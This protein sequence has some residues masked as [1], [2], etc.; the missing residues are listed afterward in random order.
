MPKIFP[1]QS[2]RRVLHG[3]IASGI[4]IF[5]AIAL[6]VLVVPVFLRAGGTSFL[7][8]W[9]NFLALI[10]LVS[11]SDLGS[12]D[13]IAAE[14]AKQSLSGNDGAAEHL[15]RSGITL[16]QVVWIGVALLVGMGAFWLFPHATSPGA[17]SLACAA[18]AFSQ[19]QRLAHGCFRARGLYGKGLSLINV[20]RVLE[21]VL[22]CAAGFIWPRIDIVA[23]TF[24]LC[25]ILFTTLIA[26]T[27]V[28]ICKWPLALA[29]IR[30]LGTLRPLHP[31][32]TG[33]LAMTSGLA[34]LNS[35]YIFFVTLAF[36]NA[37]SA[38]F[39]TTRTLTRIGVQ[40]ALPW[41]QSNTLEVGHVE[42]KGDYQKAKMIIAIG[43]SV[44]LL[45]IAGFSMATASAGHQI[46][47]LWT[48]KTLI[49]SK[50]LTTVLLLDGACLLAWM[51]CFEVLRLRGTQRGVGIVCLAAQGVALAACIAWYWLGVSFDLIEVALSHCIANGIIT[52][53]ALVAMV[54]TALQNI[55]IPKSASTRPYG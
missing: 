54:K 32:I 6:Q 48:Q 16:L 8:Q 37:F 12:M 35:G 22:I 29:P 38:F 50:E 4:G 13:A 2:Q 27:T 17:V 25:R 3:L 40:T 5:V 23:L 14:A 24:A 44:L 45:W 55:S 30:D 34:I 36:G 47:E 42:G 46:Y 7:G 43:L 20:T 41:I 33:N 15:I 49:F 39:A 51:Y 28:K 19:G 10:T 31:A 53:S 52:V 9:I 11:Q 1:S 21:V 26:I 18:A